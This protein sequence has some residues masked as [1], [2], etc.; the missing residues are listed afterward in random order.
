MNYCFVTFDDWATAQ[1]ACNQSDRN[2]DGWVRA[3]RPFVKSELQFRDQS[4]LLC[5]QPLDCITM[6]STRQQDIPAS[7]G[8]TTSPHLASG[9]H[10]AQNLAASLPEPLAS[11]PAYPSWLQPHS[12]HFQAAS[13]A[14]AA[15][16][17]TPVGQPISPDILS[18]QQYHLSLAERQHVFMQ[19]VHTGM[20]LNAVPAADV[21]ASYPGAGA[22]I[23]DSWPNF[24]PGLPPLAPAAGRNSL[25][26]YLNSAV[27]TQVGGLRL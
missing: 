23:T 19:G 2:I 17:R 13:A 6:A 27:E 3:P 21:Q 16:M 24:Q 11:L 9:S 7:L 26:Q 18:V 14:P 8:S 5:L 15:L 20:Q 10:A 12:D 1:Q 4:Q 25:L 22:S